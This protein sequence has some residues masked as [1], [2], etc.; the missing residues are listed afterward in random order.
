MKNTI[1]SLLVCVALASG[2]PAY[3]RD[4]GT[5]ST[6]SVAAVSIAP[7]SIAVVS[8]YVGSVMV[9]ES[10]QVVGEFFEVVLKGAGNASRAVV[11]V[12]VASVKATGLVAGQTVSVVAEGAGYLLV[13]AGKVLCYVPGESDRTLVRSGPSR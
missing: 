13:A 11:T 2:L 8:A 7:A 12:T 10:V 3:A 6:A 5:G 1:C 9:V 4:S